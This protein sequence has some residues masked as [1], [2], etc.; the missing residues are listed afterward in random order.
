MKDVVCGLKDAAAATPR[1]EV[2]KDDMW[3]TA[4]VGVGRPA[5]RRVVKDDVSGR[6][7]CGHAAKRGWTRPDAAILR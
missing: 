1:Q 5:S 4:C 6:G 7:A 3:V 2:V